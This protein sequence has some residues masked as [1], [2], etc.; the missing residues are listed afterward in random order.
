VSGNGAARPAAVI[1]PR[2][3][4]RRVSPGPRRSNVDT[5][6]LPRR[7]QTCGS[8]PARSAANASPLS[9]VGCAESRVLPHP[10]RAPFGLVAVEQRGRCPAAEHPAHPPAPAGNPARR[11]SGAAAAAPP[12]PARPAGR[13]REPDPRRRGRPAGGPAPAGTAAA[14]RSPGRRRPRVA[15]TRTAPRRRAGTRRRPA[16][17]VPRGPA[18]PSAEP[19][20]GPRP[21]AGTCPRRPHPSPRA[22]RRRRRARTGSPAGRPR[23]P[24]RARPAQ[25]S[26]PAGPRVQYTPPD[27]L[28]SPRGRER[29]HR[30]D[31]PRRS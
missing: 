30:G 21:A 25:A 12:P 31:R 13:R 5:R 15:G 24:G 22:D 28:L 19:A 9:R 14:R 16:P 20:R 2:G 11:R 29:S 27:G 7:S 10:D 18:C 23:P 4:V 26:A 17:P 3:P 1:A 8:R 6:V